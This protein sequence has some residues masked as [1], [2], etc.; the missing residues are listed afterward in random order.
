MSTSDIYYRSVMKVHPKSN[1]RYF[2]RNGH[3]LD[4]PSE[5]PQKKVIDLKN[6]RLNKPTIAGSC[7][8]FGGMSSASSQA[9][10]S[11]SYWDMLSQD[12]VREHEKQ[13]IKDREAKLRAQSHLRS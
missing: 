2:C 7:S 5:S 11:P 8:A 10:N 6:I 9:G 3:S 13:V 1:K 4:P 12:D